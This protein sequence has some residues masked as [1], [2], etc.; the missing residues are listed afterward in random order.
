MTKYVGLTQTTLSQRITM[1]LQSGSIKEHFRLH[2][3]TQVTRQDIANNTTIV[4]RASNRYQLAIKEA[5]IIQN[6]QPIINRQFNN[7]S[8]ILK[9]LSNHT[10]SIPLTN[11][12]RHHR[13]QDT[14]SSTATNTPAINNDTPILSN[15]S[16]THIVNHPVSPCINNRINQLITSTRNHSNNNN[17]SNPICPSQ[18]PNSPPIHL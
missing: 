2:H 11:A 5:L 3:N 16:G 6:T 10:T 8:N 7:F 14:H 17:Q 18:P 9:L 12:S 15:S 4:A 1:H 13:N